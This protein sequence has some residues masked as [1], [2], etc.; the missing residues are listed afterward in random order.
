MRLCRGAEQAKSERSNLD[1]ADPKQQGEN[2]KN[3]V[4]QSGDDR[5]DPGN[6]RNQVQSVGFR[7]ISSYGLYPTEAEII[8]AIKEQTFLRPKSSKF[9]RE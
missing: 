8:R 4:H 7:G 6:S 9:V 2:K 5:M 3:R 1:P